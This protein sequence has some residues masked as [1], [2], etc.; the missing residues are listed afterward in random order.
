MNR[1]IINNLC[2]FITTKYIHVYKNKYKHILPMR[3]SRAHKIFYS[4]T[5][6]TLILILFVAY[7]KLAYILGFFKM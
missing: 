5:L 1:F 7:V 2:D 4:I 3:H 6:F